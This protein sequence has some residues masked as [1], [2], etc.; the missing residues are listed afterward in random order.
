MF[1][2]RQ[3]RTK[4]GEP[5]A[6]CL[7]KLHFTVIVWQHT[8]GVEMSSVSQSRL[9]AVLFGAYPLVWVFWGI[10]SK[11]IALCLLSGFVLQHLV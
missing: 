6:S 5:V 9:T 8:C 7:H 10:G 2:L 3:L 1:T 4:G 11:G